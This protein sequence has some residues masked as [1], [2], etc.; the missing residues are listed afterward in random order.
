VSRTYAFIFIC[1]QGR[2][3]AQAALL[4]ASLRRFAKMDCELIAAIPEPEERWGRPSQATL[5]FLNKLGV[6][7][8][9]VSNPI[10][11]AYAIGNK[12]ACLAVPTGADKMILLDSDMMLMR[13]W[14]D[15][16]RFAIGFNARPASV[17]SFSGDDGHW[18]A[19]YAAC[20]TAPLRGK[21]LTT[22]SGELIHPYFNSAFVAVPGRVGFGQAW[23]ECCRKIEGM[24]EVP[25]KRPHLDQIALSPAAAKVGLEYDC[26]DERYNHPINFKPLI[27]GRGCKLPFFCHYHDAMTLAREPAAVA[28][29]RELMREDADLHH[30][31]KTDPEWDA[32]TAESG[33]ELSV[34]GLDLIITGI[35]RSGTSF[36]CNLLHGYDNCVV[37]NEPPEIVPALSGNIRPWPLAALYRNT[38]RDVVLGKPIRNKLRDGR[39]IEDTSV[40]NEHSMY[41]PRV[42]GGDFVLGTKATIPFLSRLGVLRQVMPQARV[43]ACVRN[44]YDTIA[45]W[46]T[47]FPHLRDGDVNGRPIGNPSDPWL[48]GI[49]RAEL[50]RI[51]G[52][53]DLPI[54]RAMWW[55]Y[56]AELILEW[57]DWVVLV[58]YE[59]LV[60]EPGKVVERILHGGNPGEMTEPMEARGARSKA[61]ALD[62]ADMRAIRAICSDAAVRLGVYQDRL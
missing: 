25:N 3:E 8:V 13:D 26:L 40:D 42:R 41:T 62:E 53:A 20:G 18:A 33:K 61:G 48:S 21:V 19:I 28:L 57:E 60:A 38:R 50:E 52:I 22:Y 31:L 14:G 44:P 32:V 7:T 9:A 2:L 54:R 35:P 5:A 10:D 34:T 24:S 45:S 17:V 6:R 46:K 39:V 47:S 37:L 4:A 43:V 16:E 30:I 12:V 15:E 51:A 11:P 59:E 56:L 55:R 23:I 49:Q 29:V 1:Q 27:Q 58:R 36:L